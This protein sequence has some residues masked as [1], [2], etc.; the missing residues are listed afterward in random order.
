[1]VI[2]PMGIVQELQSIHKYKNHN[3]FSILARRAILKKNNQPKYKTLAIQTVNMNPKQHIPDHKHDLEPNPS[4][5]HEKVP[6]FNLKK[7][8]L[9]VHLAPP[10]ALVIGIIITKKK[11]K[12]V[13][14]ISVHLSIIKMEKKK[15]LKTTHLTNLLHLIRMT[16]H[17]LL[18]Q[19]TCQS[20]I[21]VED[22]NVCLI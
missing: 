5:Q 20:K 22:K 9:Q 10:V 8:Q 1:M 7:D 14:V 2:V 18:N 17:K 6:P 12:N 19:E 13:P 21:K 15:V 4:P 11:S 3:N 16:W